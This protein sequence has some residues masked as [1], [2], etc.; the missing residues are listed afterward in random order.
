MVAATVE[1]FLDSGARLIILR[2]WLFLAVLVIS[3]HQMKTRGGAMRPMSPIPKIPQIKK[4]EAKPL[5]RIPQIPQIRR[6]T[7][8]EIPQ[9]Q[10][11]FKER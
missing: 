4:L 6:L 3:S 11:P 7:E 8:K 5:R 1:A 10:Q 9:I 2:V